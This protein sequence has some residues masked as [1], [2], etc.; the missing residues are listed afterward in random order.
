MTLHCKESYVARYR[1][2]HLSLD[3]TS[4]EFEMEPNVLTIIQSSL[5][6]AIQN[7]G[8]AHLT[9]GEVKWREIYECDSYVMACME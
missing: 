5:S 7:K 8:N 2:V 1:H 9:L 3:F 6:V 4:K